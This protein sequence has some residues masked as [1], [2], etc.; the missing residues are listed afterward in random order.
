M[1]LSFHPLITGDHNVNCAG[2]APGPRERT[3][4]A[5]ADAVILPQGV[6][7]DLYRLCRVLCP[8]VWPNYD[9]RFDYPGKVGQALALAGLGLP[10]PMTVIY[11]SVR[12]FP[13]ARDGPPRPFVL[14]DNLGGQGS[15][16]FLVETEEDQARALEILAKSEVL[17]RGGFVRQELIDHGG[18]DLRVT[19]IGN[20]VITYWRTAP[21]GETFLNNLS[22]GGEPDFESDPDLMDQGVMVARELSAKT[23]LDLAGL[24]VIF[25]RE[26]PTPLLLEIN[27]FFGRKGLGGS[28]EY[29]LM[30][31][32]AVSDWLDQNNL[33]RGP[34][35]SR[36]DFS[37]RD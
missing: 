5:Q 4:I 37:D 22:A 9:I 36:P 23:G 25:D 19:L 10:R 33:K 6:R 26:S 14:K 17:G 18:R 7:P 12:D 2:R 8:L 15:G 11:P 30:L 35:L 34:V 29:Y 16:V 20:K 31:E 28:D 21:E 24:D 1:I 32:R 3:L 27:Y 13:V